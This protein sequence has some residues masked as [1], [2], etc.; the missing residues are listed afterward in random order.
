MQTTLNRSPALR[1][2]APSHAFAPA[3]VQLKRALHCRCISS[4]EQA[5][6]E[7]L[8]SSGPVV[9][10][11]EAVPEGHKGLHNFLYSEGDQHEGE[12]FLFK[13]LFK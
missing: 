6:R 10:T 1:S 7:K 12:P 2:R 3:R 11:D 8:Q 13:V 9:V 4:N 5:V